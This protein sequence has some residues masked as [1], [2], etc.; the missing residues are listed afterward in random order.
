MKTNLAACA[1]LGRVDDAGVE[2]ARVHVEADSA[3]IEFTAI[4][5][6]VD[7]VGGI[8]R[9][10]LKDVHL[11]GVERFEVAA[12][13]FE[14]PVYEM[15]VFHLQAADGN[16]HPAVLVAMVVDGAELAGLPADGD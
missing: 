15:E 1:L 9:A 12:S 11:H 14:I 3:L 2:G 4:D 13:G 8:D 7:R 5:H 10:G 16:G 6:P